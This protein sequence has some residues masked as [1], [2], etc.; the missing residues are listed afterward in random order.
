MRLVPHRTGV[1]RVCSAAAVVVAT[2]FTGGGIAAADSVPPRPNISTPAQFQSL[3]SA[4]VTLTGTAADDTSVT[5]VQVTITNLDTNSPRS[6]SATLGSPGARSTGWR[7]STDLPAGDYYARAQTR[8]SA[9][10]ASAFS[11]VRRFDVAKPAGQAFLTL[12]FGRSQLA[13]ATDTCQRVPNTV[14]LDQVAAELHRRGITGTGAVVGDRTAEASTTCYSGALY[15]SWQQLAHLRDDYGMRFVSA[16]VSHVNNTLLTPSQQ[17]QNICGSL[18]AL[19]AHGHD[20]AWGTFAY[21]N[22]KQSLT[23]Q[24]RVTSRCFA[25]GRVY[26]MGRS[27]QDIVSRSPWL[28]R[29]NSLAGG[30][31]NAPALPCY[32]LQVRSGRYFSRDVL[33]RLMSVGPG[34]WSTVYMYKFITGSYTATDGSGVR[35]DCTAADWRA[36]WTTVP[37]TYCWNDYLAAL[38]SIPSGVTVVD[39]ATVAQ[40]WNPDFLAPKTTITSGP[41]DGSSGTSVVFSFAAD[42][43]RSWFTCSLDGGANELCDT[44]VAYT[45]LAPGPH[46]FTVRASDAFGNV[47]LVPATYSWISS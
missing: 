34:E 14:P 26:Q 7:F 39:P 4:P 42:Q 12:M 40:T 6:G 17:Y 35:W 41:A 15:P 18:P 31:C 5:S 37:E 9:G 24:T 46:T 16:G 29:T 38:S 44:G 23:L 47:E 36:H 2:V 22:G 21:P 45:G 3:S 1:T 43:A 8:D 19:V 32:S 30:A 28:E 20:R 25:Y 33:A 10:H 27:H 13:L 11:A